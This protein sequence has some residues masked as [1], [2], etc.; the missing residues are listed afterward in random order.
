MGTRHSRC[1]VLKQSDVR[2][3]GRRRLPGAGGGAEGPTAQA[4][5]VARE[6]G[7]V[8]IKVTCRCGEEI[9]LRCAYADGGRA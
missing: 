6:D 2:I 4:D 9:Q 7:Q 5:I 1:S 8:V 3:R